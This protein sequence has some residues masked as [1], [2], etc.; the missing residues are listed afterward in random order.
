MACPL[1]RRRKGCLKQITG[2]LSKLPGSFRSPPKGR[3]FVCA[4]TN[5][6]L[7]CCSSDS[8]LTI[9]RLPYIS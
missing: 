6:K 2:T 3:T 7:N 1:Q 5:F 8:V 9:E 4:L